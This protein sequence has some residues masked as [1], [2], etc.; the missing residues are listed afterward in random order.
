MRIGPLRK[1]LTLQRDTGS[2]Q[3]AYGQPVAV[4]QTVATVWAEI[5]PQAAAE[6]Q[7]GGA[8]QET[9]TVT[10]R[11]RLRYRSDVTP[12]MRGLWGVRVFDIESAGDPTGRRAELLLQC[13]ELVEG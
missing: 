9:A 4:W 8:A 10:H 6:R 13:R 5:T 2:T 12:G 11:V 3:D 1:R 7:I